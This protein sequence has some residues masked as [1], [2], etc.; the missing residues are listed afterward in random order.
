MSRPLLSVIGPTYGRADPIG[1]L[2][3]SILAQ[4]FQDWEIV[5]T[6]D[7]SPRQAEVRAVVEEYRKRLGDKIQFTQH[8]ETHGYDGSFRHLIELARGEFVFVMGD[9]D[10]VAPGAFIVVADAIKKYPNLGVI[11]RSYAMFVGTPDNVT[12]VIRNW[13]FE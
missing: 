13:T 4:D 10:R 9:D 8:T 1:P 11:I 3:D 6:E 12:R 2:I 5:I 7:A